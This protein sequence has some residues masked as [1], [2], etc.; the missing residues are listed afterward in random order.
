MPRE[1]ALGGTT[2]AM[3]AAAVLHFV[4]FPRVSNRPQQTVDG[5]AWQIAKVEA[6]F[7]WAR[8]HSSREPF[9]RYLVHGEQSCGTRDGRPGQSEA[10]SE[11]EPEAVPEPEAASRG[12]GEQRL[13]ESL[14]ARPPSLMLV[15]ERLHPLSIIPTAS[16][17][18]RPWPRCSRLPAR[19]GPDDCA[20]RLALFIL[21]AH[22]QLS[23][24]VIHFFYFE[25]TLYV[26]IHGIPPGHRWL[27]VG[28]RSLH[29]R[30]EVIR[31]SLRER[32][33]ELR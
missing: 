23:E 21:C 30:T 7:C 17:R 3:H 5:R 14:A 27:L 6:A 8:P 11:R 12:Q 15:A 26:T 29:L 33:L 20:C 22:F 18:P 25:L 19:E 9:R 31:E 16:C 24:L 10:V 1:P 28:K 13:Y 2:M 32:C 4:R